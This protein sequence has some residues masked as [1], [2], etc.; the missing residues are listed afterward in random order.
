MYILLSVQEI[1]LKQ[2]QRDTICQ[3][4]RFWQPVLL[5][6]VK[7]LGAKVENSDFSKWKDHC[8]AIMKS[9]LLAKC[10]PNVHCFKAVEV[11]NDTV[12]VEASP[13]DKFGGAGLS[14]KD[15][16]CKYANVEGKKRN[17]R[18]FKGDQK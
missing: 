10:S 14:V 2:V 16:P 8:K 18:D 11:T 15:R 13:Y 17:R 5:L 6:S 3:L 7:K 9:G 1:A 4:L 12:L